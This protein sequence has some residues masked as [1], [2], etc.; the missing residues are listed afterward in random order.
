M[1]A[2]RGAAPSYG[3]QPNIQEKYGLS[4]FDVSGVVGMATDLS[5]GHAGNLVPIERGLEKQLSRLPHKQEKVGAA[6]TP[7]PKI[8]IKRTCLWPRFIPW[9]GKDCI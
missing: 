9:R 5:S 4:G 7:A 2:G 1:V 3:P 8:I 6:P